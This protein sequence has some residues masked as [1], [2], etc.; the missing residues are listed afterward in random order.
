MTPK[1]KSPEQ[2]DSKPEESGK[3]TDKIIR[4]KMRTEEKKAVT[5]RKIHRPE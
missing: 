1:V 3:Q 5:V 4:K 2:K